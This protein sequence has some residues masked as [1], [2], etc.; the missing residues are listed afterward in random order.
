LSIELIV[1]HDYDPRWPEQFRQE[2][3]RIHAAIG[4]WI[5]AVEHIGSTAVP[6]LAAK[7]ILDVMVGIRRLLDARHCIPRMTALGYTY[8]REHERLLPERRY[9]FKPAVHL[10]MVEPTARFWREKLRFRDLLRADAGLA[11][12]YEAL[13]RDLASRF[14][15]DPVRYTEGKGAFVEEAM[16]VAR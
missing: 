5:R 16:R 12:R 1:L 15:T 6:G 3:E 4:D 13:K 2:A 10:H 11:R 7:P 9:F 14:P 8:V